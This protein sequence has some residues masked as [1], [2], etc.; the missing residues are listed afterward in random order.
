MLF[1]LGEVFI[2][3]D[4]RINSVATGSEKDRPEIIIESEELMVEIDDI[5]LLFDDIVSYG[6]FPIFRSY[7]LASPGSGLEPWNPFAKPV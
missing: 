3:H 2:K 6:G 5:V 7:I 4:Y 1:P